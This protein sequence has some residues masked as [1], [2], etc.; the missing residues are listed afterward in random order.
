MHY[1]LINATT[2]CVLVKHHM[3]ITPMPTIWV[4]TKLVC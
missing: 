4:K 2:H 1:M 3:I